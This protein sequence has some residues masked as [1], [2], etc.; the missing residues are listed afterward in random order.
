MPESDEADCPRERDVNEVVGVYVRAVKGGG[1][2]YSSG[3]A[4]AH[5]NT[6]HR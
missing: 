4:I 6:S 3:A 2:A 5:S 1:P